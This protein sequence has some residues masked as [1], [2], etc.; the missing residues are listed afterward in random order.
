MK[1]HTEQIQ[2]I[3]DRLWVF[4]HCGT[5]EDQFLG[6]KYQADILHK[7][8]FREHVKTGYFS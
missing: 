1:V 8:K 6:S 5:D 7:V 3:I 4:Q 2:L